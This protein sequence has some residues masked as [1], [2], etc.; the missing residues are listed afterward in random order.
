[1]MTTDSCT[2]FMWPSVKTSVIIL[3]IYCRVQDIKNARKQMDT[4][5]NV[6]PKENITDL[7]LNSTR[8]HLARD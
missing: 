4:V 1:M 8:T 6:R 2:V 5:D 3:Q 7:S